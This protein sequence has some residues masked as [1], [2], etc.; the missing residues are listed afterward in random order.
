MQNINK[1][2]FNTGAMTTKGVDSL[3]IALYVNSEKGVV[4][5]YTP[6]IVTREPIIT[7]KH[8]FRAQTIFSTDTG[9]VPNYSF[10]A[11]KGEI[12]RIEAK[13]ILRQEVLAIEKFDCGRLNSIRKYLVENGAITFLLDDVGAMKKFIN[14]S[15]PD[16]ENSFKFSVSM[17]MASVLRGPWPIVSEPEDVLTLAIRLFALEYVL[18]IYNRKFT[19]GIGMNV[20]G[21]CPKSSIA[22]DVQMI[23]FSL[24]SVLA[25]HEENLIAVDGSRI[26]R[27]SKV[28]K[29]TIME[30]NKALSYEVSRRKNIPKLVKD[31]EAKKAK[32]EKVS[33]AISPKEDSEMHRHADEKFRK[34][35][36]E[37]DIRKL[38][39]ELETLEVKKIGN[40]ERLQD[41]M[42]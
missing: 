28:E 41:W 21:F 12:A 5:N 39:Q 24:S 38:H 1:V 32:R 17:D 7:N 2:L 40:I 34:V 29:G 33:A 26:R 31:F 23:N 18:P 9:R 42:P 35:L 30:V 37:S 11:S 22:K 13:D 4:P 10:P 19:D 14:K 27:P 3:D 15:M 36:T 8:R 20:V 16:I 6:L 25:N